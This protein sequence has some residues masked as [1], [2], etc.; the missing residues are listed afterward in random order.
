MSLKSAIVSRAASYL[1]SEAALNKRRR[2]A[3][4]ARQRSGAPHVI[5]L[6]IDPADPYTRLLLQIMPLFAHRYAVEVRPWLVGPPADDVAPDRARLDDWSRRDAGMLAERAGLVFDAG[7]AAPSPDAVGIAN[8]LIAGVLD[9]PHA[10]IAVSDAV[11]QLWT[12]GPWP[13]YPKADAAA[14]IAAGNS[15]RTACGHYLGGVLHYGGESYWGIDRLHYLEERL[16]ALGL[17]RDGGDAPLYAPPPDLAGPVATP[18]PK[19]IHWY[20]SFR[21]PYTWLSA[22]RIAALAQAHGATLELRFIL[23][24][25]MR[26]LPVPSEKRR[27]ITFDTAREARRLCIAFGKVADP[28]GRPVERGY[29]LLPWARAQGRG[30]EFATAFLRAVFSQGID[31]GSDT[32]MQRIVTAA[33]LDWKEAHS[34]IDNDDWRAEAE[35]N[36]AELLDLGLWGAPS[37]RVGSETVWGQDRLWAVDAMLRH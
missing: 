5:D 32:G 24:M 30:A 20:L 36:R 13:L 34:I 26:S 19:T 12:G 21:S 17:R 37:F 28:V 6:F 29:S 10:L 3:E 35:A 9:S 2:D 4:Q 16:T 23:P 14:A 33:G 8:A 15:R 11:T 1:T 27:Y 22:P 18:S 31:A 7:A 25:V